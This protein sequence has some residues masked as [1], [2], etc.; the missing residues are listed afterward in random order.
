MFNC[1]VS[2]AVYSHGWIITESYLITNIN[3]I[4]KLFHYQ[5]C[6]F[7]LLSTM[8]RV[9]CHPIALFAAAV[10]R[11]SQK[12]VIFHDFE[13]RRS[14]LS[15]KSFKQTIECNS[16]HYL[17]LKNVVIEK[18]YP[19]ASKLIL[20]NSITEFKLFGIEENIGRFLFSSSF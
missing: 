19:L 8:N 2:K 3:T 15:S 16:H 6:F 11:K 10:N 4:F 14:F 9:L 18:C 17:L 1:Y 12:S 5:V 13:V 7:L 20:E